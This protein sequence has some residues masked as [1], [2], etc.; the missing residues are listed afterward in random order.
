MEQKLKLVIKVQ[1]LKQ[2]NDKL[3]QEN[4]KLK[5]DNN[6]LVGQNIECYNRLDW[7]IIKAD[8]MNWKKDMCDYYKYFDDLE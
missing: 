5:Y 2:E 7:W 6:K 1:Q 8:N 4:D 3:K